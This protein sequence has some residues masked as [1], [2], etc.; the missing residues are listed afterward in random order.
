MAN[1]IF[2]CAYMCVLK[3]F[4]TLPENTAHP[5]LDGM[6][7]LNAPIASVPLPL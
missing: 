7:P 3:V 6:P 2:F 5:K 4:E 1:L